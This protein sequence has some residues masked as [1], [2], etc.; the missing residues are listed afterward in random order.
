MASLSFILFIVLFL[1]YLIV[2]H[3]ADQVDVNEM[4]EP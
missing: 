1:I 3:R 4:T 2:S